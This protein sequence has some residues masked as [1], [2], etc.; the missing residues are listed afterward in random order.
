MQKVFYLP[1]YKLLPLL[2]LVHK[3]AQFTALK[4]TTKELCQYYKNGWSST[5]HILRARN[6]CSV[7]YPRLILRMATLVTIAAR[8]WRPRRDSK[9]KFREFWRNQPRDYSRETAMI[10][11]LS[12]IVYSHF[13][14]AYSLCFT[15][16]QIRRD[17]FIPQY[18][19]IVVVGSNRR[20]CCYAIHKC[21]TNNYW[22]YW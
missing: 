9:F 22:C 15:T 4:I 12:P 20:L 17:E 5:Q 18:K 3:F 7:H 21:I 16:E 6:S 1:S 10:R 19:S 13:S 8:G 2:R 14:S 11:D